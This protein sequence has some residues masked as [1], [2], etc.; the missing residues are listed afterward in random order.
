MCVCVC[1]CVCVCECVC[2]FLVVVVVFKGEEDYREDSKRHCIF[3]DSGPVV[4]GKYVC[5]LV[6]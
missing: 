6:S 4:Q 5:V 3:A 2:L 1:V